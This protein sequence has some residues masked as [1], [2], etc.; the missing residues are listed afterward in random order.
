M[1][2]QMN[3]FYI[4]SLL[5]L[6]TAVTA[7][8]SPQLPQSINTPFLLVVLIIITAAACIYALWQLAKRAKRLENINNIML[9][10]ENR[11]IGR[12]LIHEWRNLIQSMGIQV[13]LMERA[14]NNEGV[15]VNCAPMKK[16][17]QEENAK[18][19]KAEFSFRKEGKNIKKAFKA[20]QGAVADISM[21]HGKN[22]VNVVY[23]TNKRDAKI[24]KDRLQL[25]IF[26]ALM[27]TFSAIKNDT[28]GVTLTVTDRKLGF[29]EFLE[30]SVEG[31]EVNFA[32]DIEDVFHPLNP[33]NDKSRSYFGLGTV[34][35]LATDMGGF[36]EA[37]R[38]STKTTIY[39]VVPVVK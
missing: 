13:E 24:D 33:T 5:F 25:C 1:E 12:F 39:I 22:R 36:A 9:V 11:T 2:L 19:D 27:N 30:I 23:A 10:E 3:S 37:E 18:T 20:V 7:Y 28:G 15:R 35:R 21:F 31:G 6:I 14:E 29:S 38:G 16:L 8:V 34:R 26:F 17:L 32:P 4:P